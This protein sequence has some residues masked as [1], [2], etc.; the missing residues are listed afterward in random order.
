MT[1]KGMQWDSA[2]ESSRAAEGVRQVAGTVSGAGLSVGIVVSRFNETLTRNL[3]EAALG[4]LREYGADPARL[5]VHWVP[6]AYEVPF[7][8][9]QL[10]RRGGF[11][12]FIAL[13]CVIQGETPHAALINMTVVKALADIARRYQVPVIDEVVAANTEAQ[14]VARCTADRT[15]RGWYAA[16]A[17]M[18]MAQWM[19]AAGKDA[20]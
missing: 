3:L 11:D 1:I 10:A 13:G 7:A 5:V 8:V 9:E 14:A 6:G 16:C 19:R 18:E 4:A 17:A 20:T 2:P 15:S 12:A